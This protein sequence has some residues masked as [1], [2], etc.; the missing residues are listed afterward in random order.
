MLHLASA[1]I[2]DIEAADGYAQ[3]EVARYLGLSTAMISKVFR[4]ER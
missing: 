4:G 1:A 2:S 3:G